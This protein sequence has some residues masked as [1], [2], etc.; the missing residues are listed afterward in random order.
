MKKIWLGYLLFFVTKF[1]AADG[2]S[3]VSIMQLGKIEIDEKQEIKL[4]IFSTYIAGKKARLILDTAAHPTVMTSYFADEVG[5]Y[6]KKY[7]NPH[8]NFINF[9]QLKIPLKLG[10]ITIFLDWIA[11]LQ[12]PIPYFKK[13]NIAGIFNPHLIECKNCLIVLDFINK[14]FYVA[15]AESGDK[16]LSAL[17]ARYSSLR[18]ISANYV[19]EGEDTDMVRI[20]GVSVNNRSQN[21]VLLDTGA[22]NTS[23]LKDNLENTTVVKNERTLNAIGKIT[24]AEVTTPLS[25]SL[26]GTEL[27]KVPVWLDKELGMATNDDNPLSIAR[28]GD[29]GMDIMKNCVIALERKKAVHFY[30]KSTVH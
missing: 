20:S 27:A 30:C 28:Q 4:P 15:Q 23:F 22:N 5:L 10:K 14:E 19:A 21:I 7:F 8:E 29:I 2:I 9:G 1:I 25:I 3:E 6:K 13:N 12:K 16:V 24:V 26:N 17:D 11:V 18:R